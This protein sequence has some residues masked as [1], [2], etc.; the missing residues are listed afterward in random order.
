MND[1]ARD[2][3]RQVIRTYG[4][5]ICN[6]P[7]SCEMFIR[8]ACGAFPDES[9][10]LIEA[11]RGGVT[12]ELNSYRPA[13]A[14]WEEFAGKLHKRLQRNGLNQVECTWAVDAWARV[15]GRH[16]ENYVAPPEF[17]AVMTANR[18]EEAGKQDRAVKVVMTTIVGLGGGMGG[19]FGTTMVPGAILITSAAVD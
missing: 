13:E 9:R 11:L 17:K 7:R 2:A 14:P 19:F 8:Q 16:P 3:L 15:L 12:T 18:P 5:G 10:A 4:A 6:T 1:Q